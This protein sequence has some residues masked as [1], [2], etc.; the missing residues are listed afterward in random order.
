VFNGRRMTAPE[1]PE[2]RIPVGNTL[3]TR[4]E[5]FGALE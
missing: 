4:E 3:M 1:Q 5:V 2:R